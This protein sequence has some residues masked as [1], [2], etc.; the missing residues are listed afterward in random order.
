[1]SDVQV[2]QEC[3]D[4]ALHSL[5]VGEYGSLDE[6]ESG[7]LMQLEHAYTMNTNNNN[8]GTTA[9]VGGMN[10][11]MSSMQSPVR[12]INPL[13]I[14][15]PS[16]GSGINMTRRLNSN[17]DLLLSSRGESNINHCFL[18]KYMHQ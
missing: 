16:G 10:M 1:M 4:Y 2:I 13:N 5:Q 11:G 15:R 18:V 9:A 12:G 7:G 6:A 8:N 3:V 17:S 14:G